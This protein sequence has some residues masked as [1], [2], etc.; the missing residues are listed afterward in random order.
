MI[1]FQAI[2][3]GAAIVA[4]SALIAATAVP[5]QAAAP[6]GVRDLVGVRASSGETALE[7]RG[8]VAINGHAE[9]GS[10]Y[11]YWW[12]NRSDDCI[13]VQTR[14][15]QYQSIDLASHRDCGRHDGKGDAAAGVAVGALLVGLAAAAHRSHHHDDDRHYDDWRREQ[16]F[17]RG[18]RA[19]HSHAKQ[20]TWN[21]YR[22]DYPNAERGHHHDY[23]S[24]YLAGQRNSWRYP[25]IRDSSQPSDGW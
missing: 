19:G 7:D 20:H 11:S 5:A 12:N 9:G 16:A 24:G 25:Q 1:D 6:A 4:G 13:V 15:G 10:I 23:T 21:S 17:E 3:R 18:Y 14:N 22:R 2:R 8:Y